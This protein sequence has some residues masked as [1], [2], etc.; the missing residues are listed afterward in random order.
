MKSAEEIQKGLPGGRPI[1]D[2]WY[3][4][5]DTSTLIAEGKSNDVDV[6]VGSNR[7]GA[8]P[9]SAS[10]AMPRNSPQRCDNASAVRQMRF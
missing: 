2:G 1:V 3:L 7:E 5:D 4:T 8:F 10:E 6:L 9:S